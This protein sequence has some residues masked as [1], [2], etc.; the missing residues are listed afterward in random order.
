MSTFSLVSDWRLQLMHVLLAV[1]HLV[2]LRVGVIPLMLV[3]WHLTA[4]W[5]Q[6]GSGKVADTDHRSGRRPEITASHFLTIKL[7]LLLTDEL[8][9]PALWILNRF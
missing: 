8:S 9:L 4:V 1:D 3:V 6:E 7:L 5:T 2:A